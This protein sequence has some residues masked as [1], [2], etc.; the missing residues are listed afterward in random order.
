MSDRRCFRPVARFSHRNVRD[1]IRRTTWAISSAA[2]NRAAAL[3]PAPPRN[4][5]T[6]PRLGAS[7]RS[8]SLLHAAQRHDSHL[9]ASRLPT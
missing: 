6:P 2:T 7:H 9:D 4:A 3:R 5:T 8:A 1:A